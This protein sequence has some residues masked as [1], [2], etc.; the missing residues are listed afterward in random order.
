MHLKGNNNQSNIK[1]YTWKNN[2]GETLPLG[3]LAIN[4][5]QIWQRLGAWIWGEEDVQE[6]KAFGRGLAT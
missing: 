2:L 6:E 4:G 1:D 3:P 5:G